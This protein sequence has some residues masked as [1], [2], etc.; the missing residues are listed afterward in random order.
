MDLMEF[1]AKELFAKHGVPVTVGTVITSPDE[2]EAA[3]EA[4]G[5]TIAELMGAGDNPEI[6]AVVEEATF[7]EITEGEQERQAEEAAAKK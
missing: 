4:E 7:D 2:A 1:Q 3:A 6:E 5:D